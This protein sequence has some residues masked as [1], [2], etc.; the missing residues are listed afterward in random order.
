M[1]LEPFDNITKPLVSKLSSDEDKYFTIPTNRPVEY[2]KNLIDK[3]Y[4]DI[5]KI[6]FEKKDTFNNF[7]FISNNKEE[8]LYADRFDDYGSEL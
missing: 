8:P 7:W 5:L 2:L 6:H 4:T 1:M 3:R